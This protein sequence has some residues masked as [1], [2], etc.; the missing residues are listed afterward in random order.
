MGVNKGPVQ[1]A[2]ERRRGGGGGGNCRGQIFKNTNTEAR[3]MLFAGRFKAI[4]TFF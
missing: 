3:Y 1:K 2:Q 4:L